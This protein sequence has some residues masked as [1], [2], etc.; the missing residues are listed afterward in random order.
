MDENQIIINNENECFACNFEDDFE[1]AFNF[2]Y[3]VIDAVKENVDKYIIVY[4][5]T[6]IFSD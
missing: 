4:Y 5:F 2:L 1:Y 3:K 6:F